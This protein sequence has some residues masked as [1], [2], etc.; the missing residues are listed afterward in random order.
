MNE[1][2]TAPTPNQ[3]IALGGSFYLSCHQHLTLYPL[4]R[5]VAGGKGDMPIDQLTFR[6]SRCGGL[7]QPHAHGPGNALM[8]RKHLW[9]P[10]A[11]PPRGA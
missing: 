5:L 3:I 1:R 11:D 7:G 2:G 4:E 6:C 9:P 10:M 8:G